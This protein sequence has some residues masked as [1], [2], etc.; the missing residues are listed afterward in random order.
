MDW[1]IV[2]V[3]IVFGAISSLGNTDTSKWDDY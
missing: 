1:L 3:I 2:I